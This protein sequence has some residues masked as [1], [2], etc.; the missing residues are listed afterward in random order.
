MTDVRSRLEETTT[1]DHPEG[2]VVVLHGGGS[3]AADVPVSPTQLSVLRMVPVAGRLAAAGRRRLAV[4]RLLNS[5]RGWAGRPNPVDDARWALDRVT[6][7]LG[8]VPVA[9]VGHSLGGRAALLAADD[10]RV[11]AVV[12]LATWLAPGD[13]VGPLAGRDVLLVHG[14]A[15]RVARLA[16]AREVARAL[17]PEARGGLVTVPGGSH[18][19]LRHLSTFDGLAARWVTASLLRDDPGPT[20][21]PLLE[22]REREVTA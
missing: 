22:R 8:D 9:L 11:R 19:M 7:R 5:T 2:A 14:D 3:R 6:E 17:S 21:A 4:W 13:P 15:D 12:G 18:S 20:L 16:P 1:P 10:E